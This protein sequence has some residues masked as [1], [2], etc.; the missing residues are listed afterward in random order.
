[1]QISWL[2]ALGELFR[3]HAVC[4]SFVD[5][6]VTEVWECGSVHTGQG[7]GLV[8]ACVSRGGPLLAS[9]GSWGCRPPVLPWAVM[10]ALGQVKVS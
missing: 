4:A 5:H 9:R 8:Q 10:V 2:C 1:M 3:G 6:R 7:G